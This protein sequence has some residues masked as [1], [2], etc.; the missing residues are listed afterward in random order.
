MFSTWDFQYEIN[1]DLKN[2]GSTFYVAQ[3]GN[4]NA[5]TNPTGFISGS[6]LLTQTNRHEWN[7]STQSHYAFYSNSL[8]S[9]SNN[10]GDFLEQQIAAPGTNLS[11][12]SSNSTSG[13]NSRL[14][15]ANSDA[16]RQPYP[17]NSSE[18]NVFLGKINYA[19]YTSCH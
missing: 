16:L 2:T 11:T 7:S 1:P 5:S 15:T 12:W 14:G 18:T 9:S 13:I 19:P 3:C 4:Y 10:P 17:V 6:N 8:N